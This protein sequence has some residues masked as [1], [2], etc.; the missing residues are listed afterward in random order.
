MKLNFIKKRF[1]KFASDSA[2][3][4]REKIYKPEIDR[5]KE[6]VELFRDTGLTELG[7]KLWEKTRSNLKEDFLPGNP[8]KDMLKLDEES[9]K[10]LSVDIEYFDSLV[11]K[12]KEAGIT[13]TQLGE[14]DKQLLTDIASLYDKLLTVFDKRALDLFEKSF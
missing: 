6:K 10:K 13:G 4:A 1:Y 11:E 7:I 5:R 3:I 9:K 8:V 14:S 12:E 2:S